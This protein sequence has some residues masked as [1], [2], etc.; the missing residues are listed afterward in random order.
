[1]AIERNCAMLLL[2]A[3][4][5]GAAFGRSLMLGHQSMALTRP[6][7]ESFHRLA[8][9]TP[10]SATPAFADGLFTALGATQ[11]DVMDFSDYEGANL[12]HDLNQPV[13]DHFKACF[14]VVVDG[15]TLEHV[16]NFPVAIRNCMEMVRPGGSFFTATIPNNWCGHGFYQFSPEL[17]HRVFSPE[18]GFRVAGMYLAELDASR[19]WSV[20][21]PAEV[22]SRIELV[23]DRPVYLL[24]HAVREKE[25]PIF[26]RTP[27]Q[28]DYVAAWTGNSGPGSASGW[29]QTLR[30]LPLLRALD[31]ARLRRRQRRWASTDNSD[32]YVPFDPGFRL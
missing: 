14:D 10:P 23:N 29:K 8:G 17:F 11:V 26:A 7:F 5:N 16:F 18:N 13:P 22:R 31:A 15:G 25:T 27:Q 32:F 20:R 9:S 19:W 12:L 4:R 3:R 6:E 28:S 30:N 2:Q 1:M 24:V 21:D